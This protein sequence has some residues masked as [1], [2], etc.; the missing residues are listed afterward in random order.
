[1][2]VDLVWGQELGKRGIRQTANDWNG[3]IQP[4]KKGI[5]VYM[6][7]CLSECSVYEKGQKKY[8]CLFKYSERKQR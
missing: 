5:S 2:I 7:V 6:S 3:E 1:M 8:K 4:K